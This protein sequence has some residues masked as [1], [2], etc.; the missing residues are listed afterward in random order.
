VTWSVQ[1]GPLTSI[2][3]SGLAT[4]GIVYQNTAATAQGVYSGIS[5]TLKLSVVNVNPDDFGS[6]AGDG[7]GDD[8]QVQYFGLNNPNS[9][10]S[11]DPDGDGQTNLFE[12]TAGVI[13]TSSASRFAATPVRNGTNLE[14][15]VPTAASR[16]YTLLQSDTL[17]GGSWTPAPGFPPQLGTGSPIA[18]QIPISGA[19][20]FYQVQ[21]TLP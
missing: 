18:F 17:I 8:W 9:A 10:P 21:V 20:K 19:H 5:S 11:L 13:P 14:I 1:S 6:Y 16:T 2:S 3:T 12:F 15:T 4:A 7:L